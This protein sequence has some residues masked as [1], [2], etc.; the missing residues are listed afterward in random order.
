[1]SDHLWTKTCHVIPASYIRGYE[2]GTRDEETSRLRL[3]VNEY[4]PKSNTSPQSGDLSIIFTHGMGSQKESYEPFFDDLLQSYPRIRCLFAWDLAWHG[5]SYML[6]RDALGDEPAWHDAARDLIQIVNTFQHSLAAP[7]IG[8]GQSWGGII[9]F[10]ASSMSP[11]LF[12]GIIAAEPG[13]WVAWGPKYAV[14]DAVTVRMANRR[15]SWPSR[16]A[17]RKAFLAMK[18]YY[19][20]FDPRVFE[21]VVA[22]ELRDMDA[23]EARTFGYDPDQLD[24]AKDGP[25]VRLTTPK[26][27]EV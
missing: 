24:I 14:H 7:I 5:E 12:Q 20:R 25:P 11:R 23:E 15:E 3:A 22:H 10:A 4:V 13:L 21:K 16:A 18:T 2:R 9:P 19:A 6:N 1:M 8:M 17:A 27:Q 26:A